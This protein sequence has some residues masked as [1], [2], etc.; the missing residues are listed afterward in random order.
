MH[1]ILNFIDMTKETKSWLLLLS[2]AC[3][4]GSSFILIK[5]GMFTDDHQPIFSDVQ[6]GALRMLIASLVLLPFALKS[7]RKIQTL[8]EFICLG[9]A[10]FTGN[11]FPSF[12]FTYAENGI[13][14]GY[15]GMLNSF[16]P[17]FSIIIGLIVFKNRVSL[18]QFIGLI[19]G[20]IGIVL[21]INNAGSDLSN[22]TF[23]GDWTH[24]LAIVF[25]TFFYAVSLNTIKYTLQKFE[26]I[27]ITSLAFMIIL[28][29]SLFTGYTS[30]TIQTIQN[31]SEALSGLLYISILSVFGTALA[32]VLFNK[33]IAFSSTLFA[34]SVTYFIPIVAV[35]IGLS[36]GEQITLG[37]IGAMFVILFGV[38]VA[39]YWSVLK[40]KFYQNN[41]GY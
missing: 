32:V 3:I 25:A 39:N 9:I 5:K 38:F 27:E 15:A 40:D 31:N 37:Q 18:I 12:L 19:I 23:K 22:S 14:S 36:I 28:L 30:G 34:S 10:G 8:K 20:S 35:L 24:V 11:F 1:Q 41:K 13:S 6:V 2:L 33:V 4:W 17:I 29:P 7:L 26:A 21:L 16:T